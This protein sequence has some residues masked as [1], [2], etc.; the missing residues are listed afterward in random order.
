MYGN[1]DRDCPNR[2]EFGYCKFTVCTYPELLQQTVITDNT[3]PFL[4]D[5]EEERCG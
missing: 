2:N 5:E 1:C 3:G 4:K